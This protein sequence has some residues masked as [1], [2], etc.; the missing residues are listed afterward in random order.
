MSLH[1]IVLTCLATLVA[2]GCHEV[3]FEP[4]DQAG[5][6]TIYDNLF[7]VSVISVPMLLDREIRDTL[8]L[9]PKAKIKTLS[10]GSRAK[11]ALVL[12]VA[13]KPELLLLDD[14]TAGLDPL[15]RREVLEGILESLPAEG[16]AV[17]YASHLIHDI[18]RVAADEESFRWLLNEDA[19]ATEKLAEPSRASVSSA[20]G[21]ET[22][23]MQPPVLERP[24]V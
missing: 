5:E 24:T 10:R 8:E 3:H 18:E 22:S 16:G 17:V 13:V 1:R 19:M 11:V 15:V 14:P 21:D 2:S 7:S 12:A 6:I 4:R 9:D 23:L 20:T